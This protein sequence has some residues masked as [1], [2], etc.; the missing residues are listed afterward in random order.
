MF[1]AHIVSVSHKVL[2]KGLA[3]RVSLPG[4]EGEFE[5]ADLHGPIA[6]L[7]AEGAVLVTTVGKENQR[8]V[9]G[10]GIMRFDGKELYAIVE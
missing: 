2:Y 8:F 7:L 6:A 3:S 9:I 1:N 10:Q 5:V 4:V